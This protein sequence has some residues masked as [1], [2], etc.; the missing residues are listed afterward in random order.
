MAPF[1][2]LLKYFI[3]NVLGY[4]IDLPG[5]KVLP[6]E[7]SH[8]KKWTD[9]FPFNIEFNIPPKNKLIHYLSFILYIKLIY[10][11]LPTF[12]STY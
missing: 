1:R 5:V 7:T 12:L 8:V 6:L 10:L 2:R 9:I 4:F 11:Y 3:P